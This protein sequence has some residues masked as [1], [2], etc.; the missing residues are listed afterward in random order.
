MILVPLKNCAQSYY[1]NVNDSL[2]FYFGDLIY[3]CIGVFFSLF[4][5]KSCQV[6]WWHPYFQEP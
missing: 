6:L 1:L 2:R 5:A 3:S 4:I